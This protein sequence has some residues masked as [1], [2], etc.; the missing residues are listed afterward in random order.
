MKMLNIACGNRFHKDWINIDFHSVSKEVKRINIL[1]GLPFEDNSI[2]VVY[3]GHFLEHLTPEQAGFVLTECYR[4]LKQ[5]GI[6]R[7]V[8]P[9]LENVCREYLRV[10]EEV[11]S[12]DT[13]IWKYEYIVIEL[14]DQLVRTK[15]GGKM[16]EI[17]DLAKL[18]RMN[19]LAEYIFIR[20][21]EKLIE[22]RENK[23]HKRTITLSKI[24]NKLLYLY[25]KAVR[26]FIPKELRDLVFVNTTI[27]ERHL[28][29]YDEFSL[30]RKLSQVGFK[31]IK[32]KNYNE[33]EI[34]NF[35]DINEDGTPYKGY[36]S[37]YIE[38][39]K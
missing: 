4:V 16:R 7:I 36:S 15:S 32:R 39:I 38:A 21:G 13:K 34:P 8:V 26:F 12:D 18:N 1:S 5:G 6:I 25:L 31:N 20:T 30:M 35:L 37:L 14:L 19:E 33:S 24:Y 22:T 10:L 11:K 29:M 23:F 27:G 17:Y 28:W 9:D 3:S 2:D